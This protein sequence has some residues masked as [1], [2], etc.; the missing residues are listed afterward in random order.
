MS[1]NLIHRIQSQVFRR[2]DYFRFLDNTTVDTLVASL[3]QNIIDSNYQP[4]VI[5]GISSGGDYPAEKLS[6]QFNTLF[7]KINISHYSLTFFGLELNEIVGVYRIA[8]MLGHKPATLLIEDIKP[9]DIVNKRILIVD[10]DSYSRMTLQLARQSVLEKN[11]SEMK[12]AVLHTYSGNDIVDFAGRFYMRREYYDLRLR[13][14]WSKISPYYDEHF[15][16][17]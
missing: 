14:P 4:E 13:F 15:P 7:T 5:V 3:V 9:E 16:K 17:K 10:D 1:R 12:T 2:I 8:K 6:E 11:P